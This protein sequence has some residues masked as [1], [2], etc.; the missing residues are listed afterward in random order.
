MTSLFQVAVEHR[1][2][3]NRLLDLDLDDQ[4]LADTL[5]GESFAI[6]QKA[7]NCCYAMRTCEFEL[8][9]IDSEVERLMTL[10]TRIKKRGDNLKAYVKTCMEIAGVTRLAAGT[11]S[12]SIQNNPA[13]VDV[14]E[15]SLIPDDYMRTPEP[16]PPVAV[17][18]KKLIKQAIDDGF[19]VQGA[20][21]VTSTRLVIK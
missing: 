18:D 15:P 5:E 8:A 2:M 17:P 9:A 13:S 11:F 14:F 19:E 10:S 12:L 6:E 4:V 7:Q 3:Y 1:A 20:R 16:K 21:L